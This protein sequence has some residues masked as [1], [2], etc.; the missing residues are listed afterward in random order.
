[1]EYEDKEILYKGKPDCD[2]CHGQWFVRYQ[3]ADRSIKKGG[4][5]PMQMGLCKCLKK[6]KETKKEKVE[7]NDSGRNSSKDNK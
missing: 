4:F 3:S 1:M 6:I 2:T 5:H 7:N